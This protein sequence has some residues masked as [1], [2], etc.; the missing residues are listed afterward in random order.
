[1]VTHTGYLNS[2]NMK[3]RHQIFSIMIIIY[4]LQCKGLLHDYKEES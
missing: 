3:G 2:Y 4:K 1:M